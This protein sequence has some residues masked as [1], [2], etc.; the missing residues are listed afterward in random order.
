MQT[1]SLTVGQLCEGS[2]GEGE[3]LVFTFLQLHFLK[4]FRDLNCHYF[5]HNSAVVLLFLIE[6]K[7]GEVG[8]R[9]W[10]SVAGS[11]VSNFQI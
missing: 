4:Q 11:L 7:S 10:A 2:R 9:V 3:W 5:V 8:L 6:L 1:C